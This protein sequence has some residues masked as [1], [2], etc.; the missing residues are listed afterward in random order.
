MSELKVDG[1]RICDPLAS[2]QM[3]SKIK[4]TD[5]KGHILGGGCDIAPITPAENI[6]IWKEV[7]NSLELN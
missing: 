6:G 7:V 3:I 4:K 2:G 5:G 1:V